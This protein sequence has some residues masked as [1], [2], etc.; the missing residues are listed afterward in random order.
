MRGEFLSIRGV[1]TSPCTWWPRDPIL[2]VLAGAKR[3]ST[4]RAS[5]YKAKTCPVI[6]IRLQGGVPLGPNTTL[7]QWIVVGLL[8]RMEST[9]KDLIYGQMAISM[10][11]RRIT[12]HHQVDLSAKI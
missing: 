6:A 4:L 12:V 11:S 8:L 1:L 10:A 3:I 9:W 7:G 2:P 5:V